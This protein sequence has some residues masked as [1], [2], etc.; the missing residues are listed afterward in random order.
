MTDNSTTASRGAVDLAFEVGLIRK[1][2]EKA[3]EAPCRARELE[4]FEGHQVMR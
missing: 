2:G 4:A 3:P 1:V